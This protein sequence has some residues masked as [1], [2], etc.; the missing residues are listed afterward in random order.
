VRL[1]NVHLGSAT[2]SM[3]EGPDMR[4]RQV[5]RVIA[6]L[7]PL[8]M[9][10]GDFDL[11]RPRRDRTLLRDHGLLDAWLCFGGAE[12]EYTWAGDMSVGL[13]PLR[14]DLVAFVGDMQVVTMKRLEPGETV[15]HDLST[16]PWSSH[17]G[18]LCILNIP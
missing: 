7:G 1:A 14:S 2:R 9:V 16:V 17:C 6:H 4:S 8:A 5:S 18:L 11:R 10:A 12:D 15:T 13:A 3:D